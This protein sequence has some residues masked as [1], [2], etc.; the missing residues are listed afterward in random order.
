MKKI[1]GI[2]AAVAM[3]ASVFA[4]DFSAG[5]RLD[6]SLLNYSNSTFSALKERHDNEFYHA[7]IAFAVSGDQAG[8]A[9]KLTDKAGNS[10]LSDAWNIWIKPVDL[11]KINVGRWSTNLNQEHIGWC[12]TDSGIEQDGIALSIASGAFSWD[13]FFASGNDNYWFVKGEGDPAIKEFYT[14]LQYSAGFGTINGFFNAAEGFKDFRFGAGYNAGSLLPVGLWAN[15]I[16][17]YGADAFQRIRVEADVTATFGSIGWELFVAGGYDMKAGTEAFNKKFTG[18]EDWHIGGTGKR[19]AAAAF[20]GFYTKFTIPVDAFKV[21]VEVK[22]GDVL[23][24]DFN[25]LVYPGFEYQLGACAI[26]T[27][28]EITCAKAFA[29]NVPFEFKVNF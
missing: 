8:G 18:V 3:A 1:V 13:I 21:F 23:A 2:V 28:V 29:V 19:D 10:V 11:L 26:K 16:G 20:C 12:N 15:V 24:K 25:C 22:D 6:G 5:V 9:L 14:K 4:V 7:P 17:I 27:G